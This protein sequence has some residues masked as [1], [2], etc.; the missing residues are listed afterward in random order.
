MSG[1]GS[2]MPDFGEKWIILGQ[3]WN[4]E[5]SLE[6]WVFLTKNEFFSLKRMICLRFWLEISE[7]PSKLAQKSSVILKTNLCDACICTSI[8]RSNGFDIKIFIFW[9]NF[10]FFNIYPHHFRFGN[11]WCDTWNFQG[12]ALFIVQNKV[13]RVS[14][15]YK[16]SEFQKIKRVAY[17]VNQTVHFPV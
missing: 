7:F 14:K 10:L 15:R 9:N 3:T 5:F 11:T 8:W 17:S 6:K 12:V 2:E 13:I 1:F 16:I 4:M